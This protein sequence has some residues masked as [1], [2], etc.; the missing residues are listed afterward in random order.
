MLA[1]MLAWILIFSRLTPGV[2]HLIHGQLLQRG[3]LYLR[4]HGCVSLPQRKSGIS[5]APAEKHP[6]SL[7]LNAAEKVRSS[8][9]L[10]LLSAT[11]A[12]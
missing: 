11:G 7:R 5:N 8:G 6:R 4:G 9:L 2:A 3:D 12:D 10:L 1:S